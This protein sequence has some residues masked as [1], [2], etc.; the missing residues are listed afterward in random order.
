MF[1]ENPKK[2]SEG[3]DLDNSANEGQVYSLLGWMAL[4]LKP[5]DAANHENDAPE[6]W[7]EEANKPATIKAKPTQAEETD[8]EDE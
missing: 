5:T 7:R 8:S 6:G 2:K 3:A 1:R 4:T